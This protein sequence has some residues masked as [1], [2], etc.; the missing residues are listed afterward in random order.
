MKP[1]KVVLGLGFYG[2]SFTMDSESCISPGCIYFSA[3]KAG[4]HSHADGILMNKEIDDIIGEQDLKSTF[5]KTAAVQFLTWDDQW[6]MYDDE[7]TLKIK[8]A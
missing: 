8:S 4:P 5:D 3:E 1:S 2:R 7:K 6:V